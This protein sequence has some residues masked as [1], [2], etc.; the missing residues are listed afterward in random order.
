MRAGGSPSGPASRWERGACF[1]LEAVL[2]AVTSKLQTGSVKAGARGGGG[3]VRRYLVL[4][5]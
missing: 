1:R 5:I 3:A 2:P 4:R